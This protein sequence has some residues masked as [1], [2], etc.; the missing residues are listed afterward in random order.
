M[1][2]FTAA[3]AKTFIDI[4]KILASKTHLLQH[5]IWSYGMNSVYVMI[6]LMP[7][8]LSKQKRDK[9][10]KKQEFWAKNESVHILTHFKYNWD[11]NRYSYLYK[12]GQYISMS[13]SE[14]Y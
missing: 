6:S 9:I 13:D 4:P 8:N 14:C 10:M 2:H 5:Q 12:Y 3:A 7:T 1:L 11:S